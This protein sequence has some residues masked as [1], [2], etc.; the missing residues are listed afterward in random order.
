M[1]NPS[2]LE[3]SFNVGRV[4]YDDNMDQGKCSECGGYFIIENGFINYDALF[5][6]RPSLCYRAGRAAAELAEK[7]AE[8]KRQKELGEIAT[9]E[10]WGAF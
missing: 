9:L 3:I 8:N 6:S 10:Y 5:C 2:E 7:Q 1:A 4:K